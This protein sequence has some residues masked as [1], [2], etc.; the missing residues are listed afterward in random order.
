M[1]TG[2]QPRWKTVPARL[3]VAFVL[4]TAMVAGAFALS[5][6][7][8]R[9]AK[10]AAD[11]Q[12]YGR[13]LADVVNYLRDAETGQRGY[14]LTN[15][16]RYLAPY[17]EAVDKVEPALDFVRETQARVG[18]S[19]YSDLSIP[20]HTKVEE[21][22]ETVLMNRTGHRADA[23]ARVGSDVGLTTMATARLILDRE[24]AFV[25]ER[26]GDIV[27]T[28]LRLSRSLSVGLALGMVAIVLLMAAWWRQTSE[29]IAALTIAGRETEVAMAGLK[30]E[31]ETRE[32]SEAR[33]R[34]LQK[35]QAVGQLTGGIAHD[36]NNMLSVVMSG[37]EM[38]KRRLRHDPGES[39]TF[40]DASLDGARRAAALTNR[41]LAF[42]RNQPLAPAPVDLNRLLGGMSE[43]LA[44]ALGE[45]ISVETVAAAGLWRCYADAGEIEN[46]VLNLAVNARDAIVD[47]DTGSGKLTIETCNVHVDDEY[48]RTH[49]EIDPGQYVQICVTDT[50]VGMPPEVVERA[51]DPFFT[52][53]EVG[54]G[55]GLGLSQVFGFCKQS[56]GHASIYSEVGEGT[57]VRLYLPRFFGADEPIEPGAG[58]A[59]TPIGFASEVILLVEDEARVRQ[60]AGGMLRELGYT[61]IAAAGPGEALKTLTD[62]GDIALLFTDIVMPEMNGRKLADLARA[63]HPD[64]KV[65]Y[66][67]GYTRNAI[68]HN[69]TV[70]I[71]VAFLPKPYSIHD[72]ARKVRDVLDGK[73]ANRPV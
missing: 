27:G 47:T 26:T 7:L 14:L 24:R 34:Q 61:V 46:A 4:L 16:P 48:S 10:R 5:L 32:D 51:F 2:A 63:E 15:D 43:M 73:G 62:R 50:G 3:V 1:V 18:R 6:A 19:V 8:V 53:K 59:E 66:T 28:S 49:D 38:A 25:R 65:L 17:T 30:Q 64:L 37:I 20:V 21:L 35:M 54:K 22:R 39:E 36:F 13:A 56:G 44:R 67:T 70:D 12:A 58:R 29:Q 60:L 11:T 68:V 45:S 55:T 69:G 52:T 23:F 71:G 40:L 72:M 33:V 41:L 31:I 42:S 9:D 57:T